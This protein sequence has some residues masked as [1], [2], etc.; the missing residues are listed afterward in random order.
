MK[1]FIMR[2]SLVMALTFPFM[3][4]AQEKSITLDEALSIVKTYYES[5][6]EMQVDYYLLVERT[7]N[8]EIFVD[9]NPMANWEH[10]CTIFKFP[11]TGNIAIDKV[12]EII[13]PSPQMPPNE[14]SE[15]LSKCM[16]AHD[17]YPGQL[18][19]TSWTKFHAITISRSVLNEADIKKLREYVYD[20]DLTTISMYDTELPN[21]AMPDEAFFIGT[22]EEQI[23]TRG[24]RGILLP[25]TIELI[26]QKAFSGCELA[27]FTLPASVQTL[28]A[29]SCYNWDKIHW[30][31]SKSATPPS[32]SGAFGG[33]T[34][35]TTPT[36]VPVGSAEAYRSA[37]GWDYF[38][39]FIETDEAPSA[40]IEAV[41]SPSEV[42]AY[43]ANGAITITSANDSFEYSIY[44]LDGRLMS[45]GIATG[46][47][48]RIPAPKSVYIVK[49]GQ[50]VF[51]IF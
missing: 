41:T 3:A 17:R 19:K 7:S 32:A 12:P 44:S 48:V 33:S 15:L 47:A 25:E 39:T 37:P 30:I 27:F 42:K 21:N 8:W 1:G 14:E 9:E 36:Y 5:N 20:G 51:K 16:F 31:Y 24:L 28:E 6:A 18:A 43:W 11:N 45:R 35:K 34:P 10:D 50:K 26:G 29:E 2:I 4:Y 23:T 22:Y 40:G 13:K 49:S 38:T 46:K